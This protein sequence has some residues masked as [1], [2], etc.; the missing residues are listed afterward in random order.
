MLQ[1]FIFANTLY[2]LLFT[3]QS[4]ILY[5]KTNSIKLLLLVFG[6]IRFK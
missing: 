1:G 3:C 5:T 4:L 6:N 2:L